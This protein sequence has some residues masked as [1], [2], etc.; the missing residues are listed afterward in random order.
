[1]EPYGY[2]LPMP[3]LPILFFLANEGYA[4]DIKS[5]LL[6]LTVSQQSIEKHSDKEEKMSNLTKTV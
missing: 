3:L 2:R 5:L 4:F 1:M 6:Y